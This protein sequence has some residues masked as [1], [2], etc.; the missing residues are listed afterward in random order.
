MGW[1]LLTPFFYTGATFFFENQSV[2]AL[3]LK[4]PE[5]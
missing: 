3:L 5:K 2:A 4:K 1:T